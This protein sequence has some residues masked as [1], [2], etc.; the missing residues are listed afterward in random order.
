MS[1]EVA[2]DTSL[3]VTGNN[4]DVT[5]A[6]QEYVE[7]RIGGILNKLGSGGIVH[8]RDGVKYLIVEKII[9]DNGITNQNHDDFGVTPGFAIPK[10]VTGG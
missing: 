4:I 8:E 6:L 5:P 9:A 3:V 7:K 2:G 10:S 1:S